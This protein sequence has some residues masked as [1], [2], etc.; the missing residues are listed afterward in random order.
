LRGRQG[1]PESDK[2]RAVRLL[3]KQPL[4][5]ID[6][7]DVAMVYLAT[8]A[9][10]PNKGTWDWEISTELSESD[11]RRFRINAAKRELDSLKPRDAAEAR[12]ALLAIIERETE[13]LALLAEENR[14]REQIAAARAV[15]RLAFDDSAEGERLRR[16]ELA[17]GRAMWRSL[18]KVMK[19]VSGPLPVSPVSS[20]SLV[21]SFDDSVPAA[22]KA[23]NEPTELVSGLS[24]VVSCEVGVTA[25]ANA[26]NEP[27]SFVSGPS[28][29]V[30]CLVLGIAQ[31]GALHDAG[32]GPQNSPNEPT[33]GCGNAP[34]E[35]TGDRRNLA[36]EPIAVP[37]NAPNEPKLVSDPLSAASLQV[38]SP[39]DASAPTEATDARRNAPTEATA[40]FENSPNEPIAADDGHG[41]SVDPGASASEGAHGYLERELHP[42]K[43]DDWLREANKK[44]RARRED[45]VRKLNEEIRREAEAARAIPGFRRSPIRNEAKETADQTKRRQA[46]SAPRSKRE[47]ATAERRELN[48][49]LKAF[50]KLSG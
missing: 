45:E 18:D 3:G 2:L 29:V 50:R 4:D 47:I 31:P 17:S 10:K 25:E 48:D 7:E 23:P 46:G 5:A 44:V 21:V 36:N 28:S 6:E 35:P 38:Q 43:T 24:S 13:Q 9:L 49:L 42:D 1:A 34:N 39:D 33:E 16:F 27:T 32:A 26:P 12:Q 40:G 37:E 20:Q 14:Q 11:L 30:S 41:T 15:G 8:F 19:L 22:T